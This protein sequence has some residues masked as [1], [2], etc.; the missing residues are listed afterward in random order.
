VRKYGLRDSA[1]NLSRVS[2]LCYS[3]VLMGGRSKVT[4]FGRG[5]GAPERARGGD[6]AP[7]KR[8]LDI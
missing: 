1:G 5:D 7:F 3:L 6:R 4:Y 8:E 2:S